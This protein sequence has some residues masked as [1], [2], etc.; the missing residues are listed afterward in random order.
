[1]E[2]FKYRILSFED[3]SLTYEVVKITNVSKPKNTSEGKIQRTFGYYL[4]LRKSSDITE[5]RMPIDV[6]SDVKWTPLIACKE[7]SDWQLVNVKGHVF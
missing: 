1:M 4:T 2:N 5:V 7:A 3:N 6:F